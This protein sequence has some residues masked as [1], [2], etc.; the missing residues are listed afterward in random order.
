[1]NEPITFPGT[2]E[3]PVPLLFTTAV[4]DLLGG[5]GTSELDRRSPT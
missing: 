1:V 2:G 4:C 5:I 3:V